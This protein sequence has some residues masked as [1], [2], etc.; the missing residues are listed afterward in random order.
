MAHPRR[1]QA[2]AEN[3]VTADAA[4]LVPFHN[5][6]VG[7]AAND[8]NLSTQLPFGDVPHTIA[9]DPA[10][11]SLE[12]RYQK[13]VGTMGSLAVESRLIYNATATF[14]LI[15]NLNR[16][17][18]VFP[19]TSFHTTRR[20]VQSWYGGEPTLSGRSSWNREIQQKLSHPHDVRKGFE[21]LFGGTG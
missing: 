17:A 21:T 4:R 3:P 8:Y 14:A 20:Q 11:R 2:A 16:L 18:F 7:N 1:Y 10:Q 5:A 13:A 15:G 12:I 6:Y 9:I 19:G